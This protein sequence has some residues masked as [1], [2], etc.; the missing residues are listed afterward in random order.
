MSTRSL[1]VLVTGGTGFLGP[2]V[3]RELL[4]DG[5]DVRCLVRSRSA[6]RSLRRALGDA[7]AGRLEAVMGTLNSV[8]S[9]RTLV[10]GCDAV[11]HAAAALAGAPAALFLNSVVA[12]RMLTAAACDEGVGRFVLISSLAVYGTAGLEPGATVDEQVALDA[13]PHLRDPYTFSKVHQELVCWEAHEQRRLPLV[14]VRPGVIYGPGR[15]CL[16]NRCGLTLGSLLVQM[17]GRQ[18]VPYTYVDNCARAIALAVTAQ[19]IDGRAFNVIDDDL[20][21][22]SAVVREYRRR[23][24]RL[25]VVRV[26]SWAIRP[27]AAVCQWIS[28]RSDGLIP[29]VVTVYKATSYWKRLDYSNRSAKTALGWTPSVSTADGLDNTLLAEQGTAARA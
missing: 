17:G 1:K 27:A 19:G 11:V 2:R 28:N 18:R 13:H 4:A 15:S 8:E 10:H 6:E 26:P 22:V 5:H 16:T 23:V 12:S 9:C 29:P 24:R 20:P 7:D 14:V 25:H 21:R 3:V